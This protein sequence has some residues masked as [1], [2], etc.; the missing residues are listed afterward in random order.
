MP[1]TSPLFC[2]C[3]SCNGQCG[4]VA[5]TTSCGPTVTDP[6]GHPICQMCRSKADVIGED[7]TGAQATIRSPF[8]RLEVDTFGRGEA[9]WMTAASA[10]EMARVLL[11]RAAQLD[12][13][14]K[15]ERADDLP[16]QPAAEVTAWAAKLAT[17]PRPTLKGPQ[18]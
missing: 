4:G 18:S 1:P 14:L 3:W 17:G 15:A 10:R 2:V 12:K 8:V 13:I 16:A 9:I 7:F 6:D 5:D 11:E